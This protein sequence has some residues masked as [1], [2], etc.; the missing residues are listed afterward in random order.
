MEVVFSFPLQKGLQKRLFLQQSLVSIRKPKN[1]SSLGGK[2]AGFC[3][4]LAGKNI[5]LCFHEFFPSFFT[6]ISSVV[7]YSCTLTPLFSVELLSNQSYILQLSFTPPVP[8]NGSLHQVLDDFGISQTPVVIKQA[9]LTL[10]VEDRNFHTAL[11]YLKCFC[12]PLILGGLVIFGIRLY[13]NDLYVSIPDRLLVTCA[14]AQ[15][16]HDIPVEALIAEGSI[17]EASPYLKLM[18]DLSRILLITCLFL[19]WIVYTKDKVSINQKINICHQGVS[20]FSSKS[21]AKK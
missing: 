12:V 21:F 7:D 16:V 17:W 8:K 1:F 14:F 11:F 9:S 5:P 18:D 20:K 13:L 10:I 2:K 3:R 4:E 6:G 19:F 15:I